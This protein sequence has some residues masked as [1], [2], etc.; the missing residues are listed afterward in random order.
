MLS[1]LYGIQNQCVVSANHYYY[2]ILSKTEKQVFIGAAPDLLDAK[3]HIFMFVSVLCDASRT[4]SQS[5]QG[6]MTLRA[7]KRGP[8][9]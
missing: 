2:I 7:K 5:F 6:T 1:V 3:A 9:P 8:A 4:L